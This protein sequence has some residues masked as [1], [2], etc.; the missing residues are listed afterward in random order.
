MRKTIGTFSLIV[1][2]LVGISVW[3][4]HRE[5]PNNSY[6][7]PNTSPAAHQI[8]IDEYYRVETMSAKFSQIVYDDD[9]GNYI[10]FTDR[11]VKVNWDD[12]Y[13][14]G[15][16]LV[17]LNSKE[18]EYLIVEKETREVTTYSSLKEFRQEKK[19]KG[20]ELELKSK[21]EFDWF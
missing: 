16:Y 3:L 9:A 20:I 4:I 21:R 7:A 2:F 5:N 1:F 8:K 10:V 18:L 6:R 13:I 12:R 15:S 14:I 19:E 11:L 17:E